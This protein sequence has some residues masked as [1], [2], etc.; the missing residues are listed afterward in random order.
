MYIEYF[1]FVLNI[2]NIKIKLKC[3]IFF[4][5]SNCIFSIFYVCII[6]YIKYFIVME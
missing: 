5:G 4:T 1:Y 3:Q 6:L 2:I